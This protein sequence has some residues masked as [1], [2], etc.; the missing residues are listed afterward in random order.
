MQAGIAGIPNAGKTTLFN[1]LTRA[2]AEC[3]TYRFTTVEPNIGVVHV[4]DKRLDKIAEVLNP[5]K[6]I[7]ASIKFTDVAG[8]IEGA[9]K[10]E[11]LG[12]KFLSEIRNVDVIVHALRGFELE[13]EGPP[14]PIK[15]A[16]IVTSEFILSDLELVERRIEKI[17][18]KAAHGDK[19]KEEE[20]KNLLLVK[21]RLSSGKPLRLMNTDKLHAG[22]SF[23]ENLITSKPVLFV[24][25]VSELNSGKLEALKKKVTEYAKKQKGEFLVSAAKTELELSSINDE[26][27]RTELSEA[28]G[29]KE[30]T[31]KKV[32][33]AAYQLTGQISFFTVVSNI[34][35]AWE[36][37]KDSTALEAASKIHSDIAK[38]FIKA[39]VV[40]WKDLI[41][42]GSW[43]DAREKGKLAIEGKNYIVQ[44]GDVLKIK[45]SD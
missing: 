19:Q 31:V 15:D 33:R 40:N 29:I 6:V 38:G 14:E 41:T 10:G 2:S 12:N 30:S 9:S 16:E 39:E 36:I 26:K 42:T 7:Y 20:L 32:A 24:L 43:Q 35:Q 13:T 25:N 8:L 3:A 17:S 34:C 11:G 4:H 1:A 21:D 22:K 45:F 5:Q 18:K 28:F 37:K 23:F 44:D 27:E